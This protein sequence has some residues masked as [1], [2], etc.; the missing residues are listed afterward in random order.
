MRAVRKGGRISVVGVYV[1]YCN[2]FGIGPFMEKGLTMRAGQTPVQVST[3]V[4]IDSVCT[5]LPHGAT[6]GR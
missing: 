6:S 5:P 4:L 1:G 2:H 3:V